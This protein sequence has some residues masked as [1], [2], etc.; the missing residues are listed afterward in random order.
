MIYKKLYIIGNGFDLHHKI[1]S[2]YSHFQLWLNANE[3]KYNANYIINSFF[4]VDAVFWNDFEHG[5]AKFNI[6]EFAENATTENYPDF[7][8]DHLERELDM[9]TYQ[10]KQD[11]VRL[12]K[13][14]QLAFHD[15]I[16]SRNEPLA[17]QRILM[18]KKDSYFINF[19]YTKTLEN[20]YGIPSDKILHIHGCVDLDDNFVFGHGEIVQEPIEELPE[21]CDT[22]EKIQEYY[23]SHFDPVLQ[24]VTQTTINGV[25]TYLRKDVEGILDKFAWNFAQLNQLEE[26]YIYGWSF[27]N[28][29]TPYIDKI[30]SLNKGNRIKWIISWRFDNDK[31]NALSYL[32]SHDVDE[33]MIRFVKL[34]ELV[35]DLQLLLF[36]SNEN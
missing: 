20:L 4:P 15:W 19:N 23:N 31:V 35:K 33:S 2:K 12:I 21:D 24:N 8:S 9:A 36:E 14:I 11:F 18:D 5:L 16:C 6:T 32:R 1:K 27:S 22:D 28:I 17:S 30:L 7:A 26:I 13:E 29:D 3:E 25:N 34:E 10:S